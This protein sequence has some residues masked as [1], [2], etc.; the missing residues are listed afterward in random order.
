M[1]DL[2]YWSHED[3]EKKGD[4]ADPFGTYYTLKRELAY[5]YERN[6]SYDHAVAFVIPSGGVLMHSMSRNYNLSIKRAILNEP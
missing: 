5:D 1:S 6:V 4:S 2:N 3:G